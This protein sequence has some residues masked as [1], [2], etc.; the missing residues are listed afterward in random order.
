MNCKICGKPIYQNK[1]GDWKHK[2]YSGNA[3]HHEAIPEQLKEK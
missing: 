3:S 1:Y 2:P